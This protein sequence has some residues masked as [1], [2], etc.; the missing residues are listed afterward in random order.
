MRLRHT[1]THNL[2]LPPFGTNANTQWIQRSGVWV[3][4]STPS[5]TVP[6][7][8]EHILE[9]E[10]KILPGTYQIAYTV[11]LSQNGVLGLTFDKTNHTIGVGSGNTGSLPSGTTSGAFMVTVTDEAEG[12][13]ISYTDL[14]NNT[15][16]VVIVSLRFINV[17]HEI[18][19]PDGWKGGKIKLDRPFDYF[20]LIETF[21]GAAGGALIFYG[22]NGIEDGGINFIREIETNYGY[23]E[24]IEYASEI[25]INDTGD[26]SSLF[27]GLL[28][29]SGKNEMK[30]N[31]M[32]VPVIR[33]DF[34]SRFIARQNTPVNLSDIVDIDGN[35][36]EPVTPIT[37]NLTDQL[38]NQ[39]FIGFLP[40]AV[41]SFSGG[42]GASDY[43]QLDFDDTHELMSESQKAITIDEIK[44]H[45][46]G[47][48]IIDNPELPSP[49]F[50]F[51]F[52]GDIVI[53]NLTIIT[54]GSDPSLYLDADIT[55][56]LFDGTTHNAMT[57][58]DYLGSNGTTHRTRFEFSGTITDAK[59]ITIYLFNNSASTSAAIGILFDDQVEFGVPPTHTTKLDFYLKSE[60][61]DTEAQG[62]LIHDLIHGVLSRLGLG[63]DP[64]YSE[65]LGSTITTTKQ[66]D[67]DGCGWMYVILKGLQIRQYTLTEKPFFISFKEIWDG[68]SPILNLGLGY[69][70]IGSA[71]VIR[72]EEK[73]H[74][75]SSIVS[76][77]FSNV[78]DISS[79][80]DQEYIFNKV[81]SG[82][83]KWQSENATGIDDP[84]T[85]HIRATRLKA[86]K[87]IDIESGLI[88][89][90][91]AIETTRRTKRKKTED[92]K[93]D[94]DNFIIAINTDDVSP[95]LY[96]DLDEHFD[97]VTNVLNSDKR[98][99]LILTPLY[100]F[101]RHI[102]LLNGC[103]QDYQSSVYK[104]VSG[105]GNYNMT[106]DYSCSLGQFC[107]SKTC[108]DRAQNMDIHVNDDDFI[109]GYY[110]LP[111]LYK[112]ILPMEWE[113]YETILANRKKDIGISQTDT[114]FHLFKIKSL[115]YD[116]VNSTTTI[117][118]WSK[119][120]FEIQVIDY[121]PES[122]C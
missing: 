106:S 5:V 65:F 102:P 20:S 24:V 22:E 26:Y 77:N 23:D 50:D 76:I 32:Q 83:K 62:Y 100:N 113:E 4:D 14:S 13:Q 36:V 74:F 88:A 48:P 85:K 101:L 15:N 95:D 80:Y 41:Y 9:T 60:Y 63:S 58:T 110:F 47:Y 78:R 61:P 29:I 64:F 75:V 93:F 25:D 73:E 7:L 92:Y 11:A 86:G 89:A 6:A 46:S 10:F 52:K 97:S 67:E 91:L 42:I 54:S 117:D 82:Y 70:I 107:Q 28:E 71:Q 104:F 84:Q 2:Q 49:S 122:E 114:D 37:I 119:T 103:L 45:I 33:D 94:N 43:I 3:I 121:S 105:E 55:G 81:K 16:T 68:I 112:I 38:I 116:Y 109:Y 120:K 1:L 118:A 51:E 96:P 39:Y 53:N 90:G 56:W 31:K 18:S 111:E 66:Y 30:D 34:W 35:A 44:E 21:D 59:S 19:E 98:Y 17:A 115:E 99:N 79:S 40:E 57:R 69:E 12:V 108:D 72:V 87:E 27:T 8:D